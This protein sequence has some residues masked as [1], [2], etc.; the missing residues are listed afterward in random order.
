MEVVKDDKLWSSK[1]FYEKLVQAQF[2]KNKELK[3]EN[4]DE[5]GQNCRT[6]D[7]NIHF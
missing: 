7:I 4:A 1:S 2:Q 6:G 3:F 5:N